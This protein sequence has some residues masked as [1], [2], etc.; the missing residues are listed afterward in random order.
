[1]HASAQGHCAAQVESPLEHVVDGGDEE[2][3]GY[4]V[5]HFVCA[6]EHDV[7]CKH[8]PLIVAAKVQQSVLLRMSKKKQRSLQRSALDSRAS[9]ARRRRWRERRQ[10]HARSGLREHHCF[11]KRQRRRHYPFARHFHTLVLQ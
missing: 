3:G 5:D 6:A 7:D 4:D 10:Q 8:Q 9:R 1:M 2:F 11:D